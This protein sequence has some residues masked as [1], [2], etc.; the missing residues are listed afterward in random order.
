V[1]DEPTAL[2]RRRKPVPFVVVDFSGDDDSSSFDEDLLLRNENM[3][4]PRQGTKD[5]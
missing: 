1:V 3:A 4:H 2:L 5:Q